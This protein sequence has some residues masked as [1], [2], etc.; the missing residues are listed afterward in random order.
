ML[1]FGLFGLFDLLDLLAV[2]LPELLFELPAELLLEPVYTEVPLPTALSV[3]CLTL[4]SQLL[5]LFLLLEEELLLEDFF[6]FS[7]SCFSLFSSF[8]RASFVFCVSL[9]FHADDVAKFLHSLYHR[10][11]LAYATRISA[12]A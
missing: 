8:A 3:L 1:D 11:A 2:L 6:V 12:A 7:L 4:L 9:L 5:E 10:P